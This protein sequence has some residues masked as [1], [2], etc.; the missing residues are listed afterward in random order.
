MGNLKGGYFLEHLEQLGIE[1]Y[2]KAIALLRRLRTEEIKTAVV[3]SSTNCS[4]VLAAAGI[5]QLFDV[6]VDGTD[7]TRLKLQGK[8]TPDAFLE[9]ARRL[10]V[11]P[12][13]AIVMEDSIAGVEAGRSGRFRLVIGVDRSGQWQRLRDAGADAVVTDLAQVQVSEEPPSTWSLVF[14]EFSPPQEGIRESLCT[15][16]NGYF[17]TRGAA[18]WSV[19]DAAHYPGTYLA[20]GY[21]RLRTDIAGRVVE[22]EDLVNFPNW[23]A[24][25]LRIGGEE[26]FDV[27]SVK[28]LSYRQ[29]LDLRRGMLLRSISFEDSQGHS[30]GASSCLDVRNAFGVIGIVT[31][32]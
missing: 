27:R 2:E 14:D 29:E 18:A 11:E 15:L 23:L 25:D 31:D 22:N 9:A 32:C 3:S 1:P 21:N 6:Q 5:D 24:L 4:A 13:R 7:V 12:S 16:G 28:L 20:G 17:A 26:W 8:P 10:G 19:T 30:Q